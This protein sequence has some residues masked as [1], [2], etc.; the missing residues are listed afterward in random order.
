[1]PIAVTLLSNCISWTVFWV[2]L[3]TKAVRSSETSV[4]PYKST[5]RYDAEDLHDIFTVV[6]TSNQISY[7]G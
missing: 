5:W 3:K 7:T 6:R 4:S 1:M 2:E